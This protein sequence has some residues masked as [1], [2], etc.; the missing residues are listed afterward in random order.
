LIPKIAYRVFKQKNYNDL[1]TFN[2][3]VDPNVDLHVQVEYVGYDERLV[4]HRERLEPN[5]YVNLEGRLTRPFSLAYH[6]VYLDGYRLTK[7]D[8]EQISPHSFVVLK[9]KNIKSISCLEIYEKTHVID[10]YVKFEFDEASEYIMDKLV[11]KKFSPSEW[12]DLMIN[13]INELYPIIPNVDGI[14]HVDNQ[15]NGW[16]DLLKYYIIYDFLN[17]DSEG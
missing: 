8:I 13:K 15:F 12:T 10:E 5:G 14:P 17:G 16:G 6:D 9:A 7:Y 11:S 3:P 4:F 1:P 2:L